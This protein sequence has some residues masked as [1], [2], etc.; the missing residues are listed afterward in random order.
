M[1]D[2]R[3][4]LIDEATANIDYETDAKIQHMLREQ[5]GDRT[6][7]TIAHRLTTILGYDTIVVLEAGR[8]EEVGSPMELWER[9][10]AFRAFCDQA[11]IR[12][13]EIQG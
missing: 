5:F 2:K 3:I 1:R 9:G 7:M 6:V 8:V 10:N 13:E 4:I 11:G 12:R